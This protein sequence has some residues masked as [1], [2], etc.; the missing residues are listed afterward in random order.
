MFCSYDRWG[1]ALFAHI[2]IQTLIE[3]SVRLVN[4]INELVWATATNLGIAARIWLP[5][6]VTPVS[7]I[8]SYQAANLFEI[9]FFFKCGLQSHLS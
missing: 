1:L 4:E 9:L 3:L 7:W 2:L 6:D 5:P 8:E